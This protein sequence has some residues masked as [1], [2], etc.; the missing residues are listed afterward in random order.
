MSQANKIYI[1]SLQNSDRKEKKLQRETPS[2]LLRWLVLDGDLDS[3]WMDGM[4]TLF[5]GD[6]CLS[7]ANG[8]SIQL[9]GRLQ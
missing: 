7:L 2:V 4:K 6:H 8:E 1:E 3:S 5:D 9:K